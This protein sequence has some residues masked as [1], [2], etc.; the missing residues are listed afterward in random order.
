[1]PIAFTTLSLAPALIDVLGQ[2]ELRTMTPIQQGSLPALLKGQDL[3]GRAQTGS[4]KTLAFVLPVLHALELL[5]RR[6]QALV[7]CPTRE[8]SAQVAREFRTLG[9][10]MPGLH[11]LELAGGQ[12]ASPQVAALEQGVHIAVGTP[13]RIL[14][15]LGRGTLRLDLLRTLVLDEADRML[16]M[17]FEKDVAKVLE[18]APAA[19]QTVLFSATFPD[20]I[21]ALAKRYLRNPVHVTVEDQPHTTP[22]IHQWAFP[23]D[24]PARLDALTEILRTLGAQRALV[25]CNLKATADDVAKHLDAGGVKASALHGDLEQ[26]DRDKVMARFRNGSLRVLVAT[27]VAARGLDV[28]DLDLVVNL[29]VAMQP[30][31]HL[32]RVG[33]TGRAGRR[34]TAVTLFSIRDQHRLEAIE[35]STGVVMQRWDASTPAPRDAPKSAPVA[36]A[37]METLYVSGGRK[38][39]IRPGDI[40]GALTGEGGGLAGDEVGKIEIHDRFSY[41]AVSRK[42]AAA[43]VKSLGA[44][45]IKGR[46]FKVGIA[47]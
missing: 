21:H 41:V 38:D 11:V 34:G 28:D 19:R 35:A 40:L 44:G 23:V 15:H 42:K 31:I 13:G 32:H 8:L 1:M 14:D 45:K 6:L 27:D 36:L 7:L 22:D 43:A 18:A 2:L 4:G 30:D 33:R 29:D 37:D 10:L 16:D 46:R 47:E 24:P 20:A 39:K 26:R 12:P 9:R 5:E 17:G 25:F 3:L